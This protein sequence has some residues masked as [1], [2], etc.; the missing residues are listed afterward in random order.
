MSSGVGKLAVLGALGMGALLLF[1]KSASAKPSVPKG[2]NPPANA[3]TTTLPSNGPGTIA[4]KASTWSADPGQPPGRFLLMYDP[5]DTESFVALF[6]PAA[7]PNAPAV[8]AV[9]QTTNSQLLLSTVPSMVQRL[10]QTGAL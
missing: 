6:F 10:Q 7:T 1:A 8:M 2:W 5:A 9:G 4:I 3:V